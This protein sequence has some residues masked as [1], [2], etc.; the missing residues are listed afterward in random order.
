VT[1]ALRYLDSISLREDVI[2]S[3]VVFS[4]MKFIITVW[5]NV[6]KASSLSSI[7][8][9]EMSYQKAEWEHQNMSVLILSCF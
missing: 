2:H 6:N 8:G 3:H 9:V 7:N 1:P 5:W 4:G